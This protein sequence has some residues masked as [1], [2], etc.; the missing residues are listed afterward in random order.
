MNN[1]I[2]FKID[3]ESNKQI[4]W[5]DVYNINNIAYWE[6]EYREPSLN[7][8]K[9]KTKECRLVWLADSIIWWSWVRKNE[10]YFYYLQD[11]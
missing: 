7:Y 3:Q 4:D 8:K 5:S 9:E 11:K 1:K 6:S 10:S 2:E